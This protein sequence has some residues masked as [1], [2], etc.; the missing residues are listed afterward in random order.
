MNWKELLAGVVLIVV[1]GVGALFY[2][3]T[4]EHP[5]G[6]T[7]GVCTMEA[8]LCPD[9]SGVGRSGPECAFAEC[10][11]PN[12]TIAAAG[13]VFL[14]PV[15]YE[16]QDTDG[17]TI[18]L[19]EKPSASGEV[20][21]VQISS[22]PIPPG[23]TADEVVHATAIGGASGAPVPPANFTSATIG[24]RTY[25]VVVIERFEGVIDTA[26]YLVQGDKVLRFDAID[27]GITAWTGPKLDVSTLPAE[28]DLRALLEKLQG[29]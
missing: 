6:P 12:V 29:A 1:L 16:A 27:R 20:Q 10:P 15:G 7:T 17:D 23:V 26:Y 14:P 21:G 9:G 3:N 19:Y 28:V 24:S 2:R 13:I 11:A 8:R 5:G 18:A 22:Y 4:L 25:S